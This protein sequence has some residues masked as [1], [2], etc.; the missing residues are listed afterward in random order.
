VVANEA[1]VV[2]VRNRLWT[3]QVSDRRN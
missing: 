3:D 2:E 1:P